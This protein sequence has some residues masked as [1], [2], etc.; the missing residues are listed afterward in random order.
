VQP[1]AVVPGDVVHGGAAG[2]RSS[3][4]GLLVQALTLSGTRRTTRPA[5]SQHC[6]V[7]P[8]DKGPSGPRRAWRTRRWCTGN[9]GQH[10][11]PSR[12][13]G[14]GRRPRWSTRRQPARCAAARPGAKPTTRR[15]AMSIT[16]ARYRQPSQVG[17]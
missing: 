11:T 12:L 7:R 16:V 2:R 15:E 4:P 6:P 14:R 13:R 10:G 8:L 9:R 17:R 1:G 5:Q 3:G